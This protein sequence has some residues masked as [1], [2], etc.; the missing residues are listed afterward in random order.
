MNNRNKSCGKFSLVGEI[1][2][3][4]TGR[5]M[6]KHARLDCKTY[7]CSYC[8]ERKVKR[9]KKAIIKQ[10]T[11]FK[12]QRMLTLTLNPQNCSAQ[13][14]IEHIRYCWS[15]LR[16]YLKRLHGETIVFIAVIEL[17]KNGY[18]HLHILVDRFIR[19][20]WISQAWHNLGAGEIVDIMYVDIHRIAGYLT[21]Y[22]TKDML[23][24]LPIGVKRFTTSRNIIMFE[25]VKRE[26]QSE[27]W[28]FLRLPV[29]LLYEEAFLSAYN[30]KNDE[31][32]DL[33]SFVADMPVVSEHYSKV[34]SFPT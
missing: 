30:I 2:D 11:N 6:Y 33:K 23:L 22:V 10:A 34:V 1:R 31:Q 21:K 28:Q 4:K 19:K 27:N 5:K 13:D 9:I 17:Q 25:K 20:D 7:G 3:K 14:S 12:L 32:G 24:N 29:G 16:T 26:D 8:G 18:A 15:E